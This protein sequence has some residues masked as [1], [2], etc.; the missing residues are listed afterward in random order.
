M[1]FPT[2]TLDDFQAE[3]GAELGYWMHRRR[4]AAGDARAFQK[5]LPWNRWHERFKRDFDI[6][7]PTGPQLR[8]L[9]IRDRAWQWEHA[10]LEIIEVF[11]NSTPTV[12][13]LRWVGG[14]GRG[15]RGH[16][17]VVYMPNDWVPPLDLK[18]FP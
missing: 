4:R 3:Y 11:S 7:A 1:P 5:N 8:D 15:G 14:P 18:S 2:K 16:T 17:R 10:F 13:N 12:D 6:L 9:F